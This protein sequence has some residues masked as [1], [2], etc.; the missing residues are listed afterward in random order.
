MRIARIHR[1]HAVNVECVR[2]LR[3]QP[4]GEFALTL[5]D[6]TPLTTGRSCTPEVRLAFGLL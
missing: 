6:G 5:V 1:R 2:E 3:P 4:H